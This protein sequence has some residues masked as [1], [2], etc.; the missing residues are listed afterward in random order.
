MRRK[1]IEF[2]VKI[3]YDYEGDYF[4]TQEAVNLLNNAIE[5]MRQENML[6]DLYEVSANWVDVKLSQN[7]KLS[8]IIEG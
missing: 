8:E 7:Q 2:V 4:D 6:V 1:A 5:H 3:E